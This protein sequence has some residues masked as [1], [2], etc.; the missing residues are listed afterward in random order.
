[1]ST[2]RQVASGQRAD[3]STQTVGE[4]VANLSQDT[5]RL[6]RQELA[7]AKAEMRQEATTAGMAIGRL[8]A[9]GGLTL[10]VLILVSLAA[11]DWLAESM[12]LTWAYLIVAAVWLVI[13]VILAVTGRNKLREVNP[14]PERTANTLLEIPETV[15]GRS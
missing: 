6:M 3:P 10:V 13:A 8:V 1:V 12:D 11:S 5:S 14:V 15:K 2:E 9:A 7:L 4:I